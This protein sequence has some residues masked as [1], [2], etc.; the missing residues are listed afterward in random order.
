[1]PN[2]TSA[3]KILS[4]V[5]ICAMVLSLFGA[6]ILFPAPA[7]AAVTASG[8]FDLLPTGG[9]SVPA[10]SF[11][12]P[13]FRF[14]LNQSASETLS[15][16]AVTVVNNTG[17]AVTNDTLAG[18]IKNISVWKD[19]NGNNTFDAISGDVLVAS[20]VVVRVAT[21]TTVVDTS[22]SANN[23][24]ASSSS[25][26]TSFFVTLQTASGWAAGDNI[27]I[28]IAANGVATSANPPTIT[29][30]TGSKSISFG[31]GGGGGAA[32]FYI[33]GVSFVN[34]TTV[35]VMFND[36]LD[37]SSGKTTSTANYTLTTANPG[38][39]STV[40]SVTVLPDNK[41]VRVV[42]SGAIIVSTGTD[43]IAV[44]NQVK[45]QFGLINTST[46]GTPI[47][48]ANQPLLISELKV[49]TA[50]DP[51]D[52]FVEIYNRSA[53]AVTVT[54]LKLHVV[55][56]A[57]TVDVN[58]PISFLASTSTIAAN[59]FM[60]IAPI[61]SPASST[62]DGIYTTSTLISLVPNGAAYISYST[63]TSTAVIDRVCWGTHSVAGDCEG[64]PAPAVGNDGTSIERKAFNSST[65]ATMAVG[66]ADAAMGNGVDTQN[67][68][69][70]F[71]TRAVP[72]PQTRSMATEAP[73][74]GS[75]GG[76]GNGAPSIQHGP[77]FNATRDSALNLLARIFDDGGPLPGGN[78]QLIFCTT[79]TTCTP[80]SST[81][82]YGT[83]IGS[84]WY[85]FSSTST[86]WAS[87]RSLMKYYLQAA[88][89]ATPPKTTVFTSD[90]NY[91]SVT[92]SH[93]SDGI[94]SPSLQQSKALTINLTTGNLGTAA[95]NG[96]VQDSTGAG[97]SGATVWIE[98]TQFAA[99]TGNDGAFSFSNVGP[100]GGATIKIAK[101]GFLDQS[102]STF[103]P[104]SGLVSLP[105]TTL[106]SG[107]MGAGGDYNL[108]KVMSSF[109]MPGMNSAPTKD[110]SGNPMPIDIF[111]S[112]TM[113]SA[114]ITNADATTASS[115]IYLTLA[116]S[117]T[118]IAGAVTAPSGTQARFTPAAALT[119]GAAYTLFVTPAVKD[120]VGNPISGN[121][122]GGM[123]VLGF[124]T[125]GQMFTD[126]SQIGSNYGM[127]NAF[128]PYVL[129]ASPSPGTIN[130]PT[131]T[132]V[133]VSFS[134]AM[135]NSAA[136]LANIQLYKVTNPFTA[137]ESKS[138]V[139]TTNSLDSSQK[140]VI[141]APASSLDASSQYR[142]QV[143]GGAT[144]GKGIPVGNPGQTGFATNTV[145][146]SDF[147]TGSGADSV[148]PSVDSTIP[149][150]GASGVSTIKPVVIT[151]SEAI[152]PST[153]S[154]NSVS[155]KL[156]STA[157]DGTLTYD[158]NKWTATF[159]PNYAFTASSTYTITVTT[160]VTDL[161]GN[162]LDQDSVTAGNQS[163]LRTFTTG[164]ADTTAPLVNSAQANDFALKVSFSK[165]MLAVGASDSNYN[166]S[167]LKPG[168]YTVKQVASD[169]STVAT[170]TLPAT[171]T[172]TYDAASRS[173][174]VNGLPPISGFSAGSTLLNV[175][176]ANVKDIG[177]NSISATAGNAATSTAQASSST[178]GFGGMM[179]MFDSSGSM[180][181]GGAFGPPP[182]AIKSFTDS[183]IGFI[184]SVKVFPFN[185][186]AGALTNYHI[187]IPISKQIPATGY[188]DIT[189]PD[190]TD[191]SGAK[192]DPF[193]PPNSDINGP[194][195]GTVVFGSEGTLP[196]GW[197]TGGAANDGVLVNSNSP[198]VRV[199]L[200]AVAT[201]C[202]TG[203][204]SPCVSGDTHDYLHL[205]LANI[206]N[207][208]AVTKV[209]TAGN[210]ASVA[211]NK[212]DGTVIET[213]SSGSFFTT[214]AGTLSVRG[215]VLSGAT[216][217]NGVNVFLMS[218]MTGAQSTSSANSVY[219]AADGEF[220]FQNLVA[221]N[222]M[223]GVE[224][225]FKSGGTT[226]TASFPTPINLSSTAC[227]NNICTQNVSVTD[228]STGV[229]VTLNISGTFSNDA[230]D[231]FGSGPGAF[232]MATTT[233]NGTLTNNT[234]NSIKLN[235]NGVWMVGL[236]PSMSVE[237]FGKGGL[238]TQS[239]WMMPK[240]QQVMITG[241]PGACAAYPSTVSFTVASAG[242]T[243]KFAVKDDSGNAIGFAHVNAYSPL[244]V[245]GADT[246]VSADGTGSINLS[247]GTY[248]IS[249]EVPGMPGGAEHSISIRSVSGT[250]KVFVDGS[251]SGITL[252]T[253]TSAS[254][255]LTLSKPAFTISGKVTD[256]TNP[257]G[258][259]PVNA[260]RTDGPGH[261]EN[262]SDP[263]TGNYTLYVG[264]GIWKVQA[265]SPQYGALASKTITIAGSNSSSQNFEPNTSS[266]NYGTLTK[267]VM[268]DTNN[269]GVYEAAS[270]ERLANVQV[271]VQGTTSAGDAYINASLT[272]TNGSSTFK[273][274]P[275][276]YTM[277]AFAPTLGQLPAFS[278]GVVV[279]SSGNVTTAPADL[280]V[281]KKGTVTINIVDSNGNSTTTPKAAFE[282]SLIGGKIDKAE[283]FSN[284]ASSTISLPIY[285][286]GTD[287]AA[288]GLASSTN[289][290]NFYLMK[291][292][293]PG[294]SASGLNVYGDSGT[295]MATS[296]AVN[297][298]W[299]VEVDDPE[300]I[301]VKLPAVKYVSGT[302]K[303][304]SG[305]AVPD[306]T[307]YLQNAS[308]GETVDVKADSSGN[309]STKVSAGTYMT[310]ADKDGYVSTSTSVTINADGALSDSATAV[311]AASN[312][313]SGTV[314][315]AGSAVSGATVKAQRL[316][317]G[318]ITTVTASDG[319]YSLKV[320]AGD[321]KVSASYDGYV[322]KSY[323][324]V[325]SVSANASGI[326]IN[327]TDSKSNLAA[328]TSVAVTP[329]TGGAL[330][331]SSANV[332]INANET[333]IASS[334]NNYTLN[335]KET[336]NVTGGGAGK[337]ISGEA[338]TIT[339]Y[340]NDGGAVTLLNKDIAVNAA[341]STVDLTNSLPSLTLANVEKIKVS[342]WDTSSDDWEH[343]PTTV[344]YKDSNGKFVEPASNLSNVSTVDF[345]GFTSHLSVFNPLNP[346][347]GL[348]PSAPSGVVAQ[349]VASSPSINITWVAPTTNADTSALTDLLG[350]EVYR[351]TAANG[352]YV[353]INTSDVAGTSFT[354]NTS[355]VG[356]SYY[357]KVTAADT[358]GLESSLSSSSDVI[359]PVAASGGGG[360][361]GGGGGVPV[362]VQPTIVTFG[363]TPIT[364]SGGKTTVSSSVVT[365]IFNVNNASQMILSENA[366]F[367]GASW[368]TYAASRFFVLSGGMGVK[369]IYAKFRTSG[370]AE[371]DVKTIDITVAASSATTGATPVVNVTPAA[372]TVAPVATA[373][374]VAVA[375]ASPSSA[376]SLSNIASA[377]FQPGGS[378]K[379]SYSYRNEGK[380]LVTVKILRE[381]VNSKGK[382]VKRATGA[383]TL[384]AGA[385]L[386]KDISE[387]VDKTLPPGNYTVK[388][389]IMDLKN[390]ALADNSFD[391]AI[392][393][394]KQ[395]YFV[396]G[397]VAS[398]DGVLMFDSAALAK[399][400]SNVRLPANLRLK[401]SYENKTSA[402][403]II[404]MVRELIDQNGKA[405]SV[406][407]GKWR[408]LPG[409][410]SSAAFIQPVAGNLS[411]GSYT[412]K[413][414]AKDAKS[415]ET[416][417]ENSL[418]FT[419][420]I[421]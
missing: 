49:G 352:A 104:S 311:L 56:V 19:A 170:L 399:V 162:A 15:S 227:A 117:P 243:I 261:A 286:I 359:M 390:K 288:A 63:A 87:G 213:L 375:V 317:G 79:N 82:I 182:T 118:K 299:K 150:S 393:Q 415:G 313:I 83:S 176:V 329:Q 356:I 126:V 293:I 314:T 413:L 134:E 289:P 275:G 160:D 171:A 59:G 337:P 202:G 166:S 14:T 32:G 385:D 197:T 244:A 381:I 280:L 16:V 374:P 183:G 17:G 147:T 46:S 99:V 344:A 145:F 240:P 315:V 163:L 278:S 72:L 249:A 186:I 74:G 410:K 50:T 154:S 378:L 8:A 198:V 419:I 295:V 300:T 304:A 354:D 345:T 53:G 302:V 379:F 143:L 301:T 209:N 256:G 36:F 210:T 1:M 392:E 68:S 149:A 294:V 257:I 152:N 230:V 216:G 296:T 221:G 334:A 248:K 127:G 319:S 156:G 306:A 130:A 181:Q 358:G 60:L 194:G 204:T 292:N 387:A 189:F 205:D 90:P 111:F 76:A 394:L 69:Y 196:S 116:G 340:N 35:D 157:V 360:G 172:I 96:L 369:R 239:A 86:D 411:A 222:Y 258:N 332:D 226:Y 114:T 98:G 367:A 339:S 297:G 348:A 110:P 237:I 89:S 174:A 418:T 40:T 347:D 333:A 391:I 298:L 93:D 206:I 30:I 414:T 371:S 2:R 208:T 307:V 233:L 207:P 236:Q 39:N 229:A 324:S 141:L 84:G 283:S 377:S 159:V 66:G 285:A 287:A 131:N 320:I 341:Y 201:R 342:S 409:E 20:Q 225:V 404:K 175:V 120:T 373:A 140:I 400:K 323:S 55:N 215:R 51:Y 212:S 277:K 81:P 103:I 335:E 107:T 238:T 382:V 200:G 70:D 389:R 178:G 132:K 192:K 33:S 65:S 388:V 398:S 282:F 361:G 75:Y 58:A 366:D 180:I 276:N 251:S 38:D 146:K 412:I 247:Y 57:G 372:N 193:S 37:L 61:S 326:N 336:S 241:C 113:N 188:I 346:A 112:K 6:P 24:I 405:V 396:L 173:V 383:A 92:F 223:L 203:N 421:K 199:M 25:L 26:P 179:P 274:P 338:K 270:D 128:P 100:A 321:W 308:T 310:K 139:S 219:G 305:T 253:M 357:Y 376:V 31:T 351:S 397:E 85:K 259:V 43:T 144:S 190:G 94:P 370:G 217:L 408:M 214:A 291:V 97:V 54:G 12:M 64:S 246:N 263:S 242:K 312:T 420:E 11:D 10:S 403:Q 407:T 309:Y 234:S 328:S 218:P 231:I 47:L 153:V 125:A 135:Q 177:F 21:S 250:D 22:A 353:Q 384:K 91:D 138:L 77:L 279:D 71:V 108:P 155:V 284:V 129:G 165:P 272:D 187:E 34:S 148:A 80:A 101:N 167:V 62:A 88:D 13:V 316:G 9:M 303:D 164:G 7:R 73:S 184:P 406:K 124:S 364:V 271:T 395:K 27:L 121:G 281:P 265:M 119:V 362:V 235:A 95:I 330:A 23:T 52:E 136:N 45:S 161:A 133:F 191:V 350:Y 402:K 109:P 3:R 255:T 158:P 318:T 325:V 211:T 262:F 401:F 123:Y 28:N 264:N 5:Q 106:Y 169:G 343:M 363:A 365:L 195:P 142:V 386:K 185:P 67:N 151:F 42:S 417:A 260:Y 102:V 266:I 331:D 368:E 380:K 4:V 267:S 115:N 245:V 105:T 355:Q 18:H 122:G 349:Q 48:S 29:A 78:T 269:S 268:V 273:L 322:E 228:A 254:L 252:S 290:S 232:R 44:N 220:Q 416:L 327:I 41:S 224:K 168:N 137:S